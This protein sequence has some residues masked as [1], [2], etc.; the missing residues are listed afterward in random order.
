[1]LELFL[2]FLV[3]FGV[4]SNVMIS[5]GAGA[6]EFQKEKQ[7]IK[8]RV[9]NSIFLAIGLIFSLMASYALNH[10]I[11]QHFDLEYLGIVVTVLIVGIYN[12][13]VSK[14]FSKMS[15]YTKYLYE[16]SHSFAIDFVFT[17]AVI[18]VVDMS[19]GIIEFLI[20]AGTIALTMFVSNLIFGL[21]VEDANKSAV[22]TNYL[23]VPSRLFMMAIFSMI[24]YYASLLIK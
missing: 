1:M 5:L 3:L 4:K 10:Y 17:L 13:I 14:I 16:E 7:H 2:S 20:M 22:N 8:F 11:Y 21:Y 18:F 19:Y 15:H 9:L 23:N 24:L 6:L 12:L